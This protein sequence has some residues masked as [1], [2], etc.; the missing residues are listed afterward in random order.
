MTAAT[1][2]PPK[3]E[4]AILS[5][6]ATLVLLSGASLYLVGSE[7]LLGSLGKFEPTMLGFFLLLVLWQICCRFVRWYVFLRALSLRLPV[8]EAMLYYVAGM[9]MSLTPGRIGEALRLWF[10]EKRL[11]A[12]YRRI[13]GLYLADRGSDAM[14]YL[15]MLAAGSAALAHG[16]PVAWGALVLI[17]V[18]TLILMKPR[19][20]IGALSAAFGR[21]RRG[22]R[23][24]LWMRRALRNTATLFQPKVFLPGV[25]I[26]TAGWLA[27]PAVLFLSLAQLG[28]EVDPRLALSVS[29][30]ASLAGGVTMLPGGGG[31]TET[32]LV[33]LL[34]AAEVPLDAAVSAM[35]MTRLAFLVLPIALGTLLLPLALKVCRRPPDD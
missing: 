29:A 4:W 6:V 34:R 20:L 17:I 35:I 26:G 9:S 14:A 16:L 24:L 8:P 2:R 12:P 32:V 30:A 3:L 15:V 5:L 33:V 23:V 10:L 11:G 19:T 1:K 27:A 21:A 31:A 28:T 22:R 7:A 13:A 18:A 25:A